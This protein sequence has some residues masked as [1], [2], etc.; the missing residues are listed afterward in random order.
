[1]NGGSLTRVTSTPLSSPASDA[2]R[3]AREQGAS[4]PGTPWSASS[5]TITSDDSTIA[6]ADRQV[7]AG[8]QDDQRL[9]DRER[10]DDRHLLDEQRQR[11]RAQEAVGDDAEDDHGQHQ[12]D[13]RAQRRVAVQDGA[14]CVGPACAGAAQ[15]VLRRGRCVCPGVTGSSFFRLRSRCELLG[16]SGVPDAAATSGGAPA[17]SSVPRRRARWLT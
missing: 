10:A 3:R 5:L 7:D 4:S 17:P 15:Q 8:G 6:I 11:L 9:A 1:M 14:G 13:E 16:S 12:H 2:D